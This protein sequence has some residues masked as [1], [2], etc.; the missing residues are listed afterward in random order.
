MKWLAGTRASRQG[1]LPSTAGGRRGRGPDQSSVDAGRCHGL[2]LL[3]EQES[4]RHLDEFGLAHKKGRFLAGLGIAGED[5]RLRLK[6][7]AEVPSPPTVYNKQITPEYADLVIKMIRKKPADRFQSV[8][9]FLSQFARV[10]V[11]V[12]DPNP[13]DEL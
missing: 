3:A 9:E 5:C 13:W 7:L 4:S 12:D 8:Q 1:L 10:K 6:H 11:F 2:G